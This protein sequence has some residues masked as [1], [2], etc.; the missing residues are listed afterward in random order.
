MPAPRLHRAL[1]RAAAALYVAAVF[2]LS[3][4]VRA[5]SE[6]WWV[7]TFLQYAPLVLTGVPCL[8]FAAWGL[9]RKDAILVLAALVGLAP[10][11]KL[12][13]FNA[14]RPAHADPQRSPVVLMT[15]NTW[16]GRRGETALAKA[17]T[18]EHPD[19]VVLQATGEH[20]NAFVEK[21][22]PGFHTAAH[23]QFFLATRYPIV[24]VLVA[25]ESENHEGYELETPDG[26]I[27]LFNMH[28]RSPRHGI[29]EVRDT[30]WKR[31]LVRGLSD[32]SRQRFDRISR[33][34]A[35]QISSTLDEANRT[36][37]PIVLAGD[38]NLPEVSSLLP[39]YF[40]GYHD[41]FRDVGFGF[42]YTFPSMKYP[43]WMRIDRVFGNANI[44]FLDIHTGNAT[45]SDHKPV[46]VRF[47]VV[48]S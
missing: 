44:R 34:R 42:G 15:L 1:L 11:A 24:R 9:F 39:L 28:P 30:G 3:A 45:I 14:A 20:L 8:L 40:G 12:S 37:G 32:K 7:A 13:G 19:I 23:G 29:D 43:S 36:T 41:A 10:A 22:L 5:G 6:R 4:L 47:E 16:F 27:T 25:P 35:S 21:A 33:E 48:G 18:D 31:L 26:R 17:I 38:T 2:G 46:I